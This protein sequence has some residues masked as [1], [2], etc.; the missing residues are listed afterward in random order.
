MGLKRGAYLKR[1]ANYTPYAT[2]IRCV[3]PDQ[4]SATVRCHYLTDGTATFAFTMRRA[5]YFIPV[6][7]LLKC[8]I[9]VREGAGRSCACERGVRGSQCVCGRVR[10]E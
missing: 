3:C 1:G 8:F 7:I 5:E 6:G 9:E 10:N 4:T 2:L